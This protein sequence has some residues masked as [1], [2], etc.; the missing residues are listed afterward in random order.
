MAYVRQRKLESQAAR[1]LLRDGA[2]PD[3]RRPVSAGLSLV[4]ALTGN[5][6][7]SSQVSHMSDTRSDVLSELVVS[8][9]SEVA[10]RAKRERRRRDMETVQE[11]HDPDGQMVIG[12]EMELTAGDRDSLSSRSE[13]EY[14]EYTD[15]SR[16][17]TSTPYSEQGGIG[18]T[19]RTRTNPSSSYR[20]T[21]NTDS[22]RATPVDDD[23]HEVMSDE[24]IH[25]TD[26]PRKELRKAGVATA[27]IPHRKGMR[28]QVH[29]SQ[30]REE[31]EEE[32]GEA[33]S[34]S[35]NSSDETHP[36]GVSGAKRKVLHP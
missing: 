26:L 8:E 34:R 7:A 25:I 22:L 3:V 31:G 28:G 16:S 23:D 29:A 18:N 9:R 32:G 33:G 21:P 30:I 6:D 27:T 2:A 15:D 17:Y 11:L 12:M 24:P 36:S 5:G 19:W 4:S 20:T 35:K 10:E 14:L 13:S 1:D